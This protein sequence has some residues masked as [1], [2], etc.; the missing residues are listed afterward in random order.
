MVIINILSNGYSKYMFK[1]ICNYLEIVLPKSNSTYTIIDVMQQLVFPRGNVFFYPFLLEALT[2][3]SLFSQASHLCRQLDIHI[4]SVQILRHHYHIT[5]S[6]YF[7]DEDSK[8]DECIN[9]R[10]GRYVMFPKISNYVS[11][12]LQLNTN[13]NFDKQNQLT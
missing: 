5:T 10:I 13:I 1:P 6:V 3:Q 4:I 2:Y 12:I 11:Y 8:F 7:G 9:T